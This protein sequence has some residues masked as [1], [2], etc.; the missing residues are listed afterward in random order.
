MIT[1]GSAGISDSDE[2]SYTFEVMVSDGVSAN[3]QYIDATVDIDV[4]DSTEIVAD[5]A[6]PYG[7]MAAM[8]D[9]DGDGDGDG[10]TDKVAGYTIVVSVTDADVPMTLFNLGDMVTD[11]DGDDL[12]FSVSGNPSH[13]IH[14]KSSD[15]LDLTYLPPGSED[16]RVD[17]ITVGVSD[18]FNGADD[19]RP[20][21][22]HRD[23]G[24]GEAAG[25]DHV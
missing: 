6:L 9:H 13:V 4:N 19:R 7:I 16:G 20:D 14:D 18:G 24:N 2:T 25:P 15:N 10:A 23:F 5:D 11:A 17:T 21:T 3:N 22:I 1:V 8:I 12:R